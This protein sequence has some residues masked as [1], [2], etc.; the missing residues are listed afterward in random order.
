MHSPVTSFPYVFS[1]NSFVRSPQSVK[2]SNETLRLALT[3]ADQLSANMGGTEILAPLQKVYECEKIPGYF[4]QVFILTD[5]E[6]ANTEEIIGITKAHAH[7]TRV[8]TLGI[9][10]SASHHLVEGVAAAGGG[11]SAFVTD[12]EPIDRKVL[13]QLKN[14]IQPA[15]TS[16]CS[17]FLFNLAN[18]IVFFFLLDVQI[19][20]DGLSLQKD[21][22][23]T[24]SPVLVNKEKTLMGYGKPLEGDKPMKVA[25]GVKKY[26]QAPEKIPPVFDGLQSL[27]FGIFNDVS[28]KPTAA[29]ITAE[30]P[31][32]PLSIKIEVII[33]EVV[34]AF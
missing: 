10:N 3:Y 34:N 20:W 2:Y 23:E 26:Q 33:N 13:E 6:V 29:L 16:K 30:S 19:T 8:F 11:T 15:L 17:M 4:R 14:A 25:E 21:E 1:K 31:D 28:S 27:I 32:G 12:N 5:G 18:K 24:S 22:T 7:E 9:G